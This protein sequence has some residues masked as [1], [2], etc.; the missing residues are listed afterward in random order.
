MLLKKSRSLDSN[1]IRTESDHFISLKFMLFILFKY[2][3]KI[4]LFSLFFPYNHIG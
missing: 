3:M 4:K 1:P 2:R